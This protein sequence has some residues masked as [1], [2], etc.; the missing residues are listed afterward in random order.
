[1]ETIDWKSIMGGL[2]AIASMLGIA[3]ML[4]V[5]ERWLGRDLQRAKDEAAGAKEELKRVEDSRELA[6]TAADRTD[7]RLHDSPD[8]VQPDAI[9]S[10]A[11][12]D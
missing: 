2:I 12:R 5:R 8:I 3:A 6:E 11:R 4:F 7:P 1:M 9:P 10:W